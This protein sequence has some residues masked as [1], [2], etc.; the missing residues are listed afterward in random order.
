MNLQ[1]QNHNQEL[2]WDAPIPDVPEWTVI[3]EGTYFFQVVGAARGQWDE[4]VNRVGGSK[5]MDLSLQITDAQG[6]SYGEIKDKL[7]LHPSM[8]W[9]I[10]Q[11]WRAVGEPVIEG[12]PFQAPWGRILGARGQC[13]LVIRE[14]T[15][16]DGEKKEINNVKEFI[17]EDQAQQ[18]AQM[19]ATPTL[20]K[21]DDVPF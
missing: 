15:N 7:T 5:Y 16:K 2:D 8:I 11:F 17:V 13:K 6:I 21:D 18:P 14:Y 20:P 12:Q 1:N 19:P 9:K 10:R 4:K 3:P